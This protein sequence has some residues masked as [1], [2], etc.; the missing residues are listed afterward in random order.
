M[1][2]ECSGDSSLNLVLKDGT[3]TSFLVVSSTLIKSCSFIALRTFH[4]PKCHQPQVT[5]ATWGTYPSEEL[6]AK[7]PRDEII[8]SPFAISKPALRLLYFDVPSFERHF[9]CY[10]LAPFPL[11]EVCKSVRDI[12]DSRRISYA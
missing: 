1:I 10:P 8:W 2:L 6:S 5:L 11:M 9:F 3:T 4:F 7:S 12:L